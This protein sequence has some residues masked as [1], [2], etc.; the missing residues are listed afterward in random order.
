MGEDGD[1]SVGL[2]LR[3]DRWSA[4]FLRHKADL[5]DG[6]AQIA[7]TLGAGRCGKKAVAD[8]LDGR[9]PVAAS[10]ILA[11][12]AP[13]GSDLH[14]EIALFH[15]LVAP[16]RADE[17]GLAHHLALSLQQGLEKQN[18]T[19]PK[20]NWLATPSQRPLAAVK[21]KVTEC[22]LLHGRLHASVSED[23]GRV[24]RHPRKGLLSGA[25]DFGSGAR[26]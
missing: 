13:E 8:A 7:F 21:E 23:F 16:S 22:N 15:H 24:S 12:A 11:E 9:D 18:C 3:H 4:R 1:Q 25:L 6:Q 20:S 14:R 2:G 10:V 17:I 5:E 19:Q 26:P